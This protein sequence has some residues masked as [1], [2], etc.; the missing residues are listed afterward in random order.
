MPTVS[1]EDILICNHLWALLF[2]YYSL[3]GNKFLWTVWVRHHDSFS[4]LSG[5]SVDPVFCGCIW[6]FNCFSIVTEKKITF[7]IEF[8]LHLFWKSVD[9]YLCVC[10]RTLFCFTVVH[11]N[12][13]T[14]LYF[15][16]LV[17]HE[18]T[19]NITNCVT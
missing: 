3:P 7:S 1:Q 9:H 13:C 19:L 2:C 5:N 18:K 10:F 11:N 8:L 14:S 4:F 6:K 15:L 17:N 12:V 16:F